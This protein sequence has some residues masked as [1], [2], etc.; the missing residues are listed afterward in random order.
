MD[1]KLLD[2][3]GPVPT[4]VDIAA[5]AVTALKIKVIADV[6][7]TMIT[8]VAM[9]T[10]PIT[11]KDFVDHSDWRARL[12]AVGHVAHPAPRC[13]ERDVGGERGLAHAGAACKHD[14]VGSLQA[15]HAGIAFPDLCR[16]MVEDALCR[17]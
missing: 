8:L 14:K 7:T 17:D 15:A 11:G 2:I 1:K 5:G 9:L 13:V 6:T 12:D 3:L 4:G 16:W 10:N